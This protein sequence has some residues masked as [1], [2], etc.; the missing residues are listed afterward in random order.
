MERLHDGI[1]GR[2]DQ[3]SGYA[4]CCKGSFSSRKLPQVTSSRLP[5]NLCDHPMFLPTQEDVLFRIL[6]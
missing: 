2:K 1:C 4:H 5:Q 6:Y 3:K